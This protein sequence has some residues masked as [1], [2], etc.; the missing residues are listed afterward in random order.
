MDSIFIFIP[1][2]LCS[3]QLLQPT[4]DAEE[5]VKVRFLAPDYLKIHWQHKGDTLDG[6]GNG[7]AYIATPVRVMGILYGWNLYEEK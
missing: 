2:T 6:V 5:Q 4:W 1:T 3:D 7:I